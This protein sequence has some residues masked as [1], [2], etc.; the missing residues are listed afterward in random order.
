MEIVATV[1]VMLMAAGVAAFIFGM[2]TADRYARER[3][4]AVKDALTRQYLRLQAGLD[5]DDAPQPYTL[6]E[7][8]RQ[9]LETNGR[10]VAKISRRA[11]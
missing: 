4:N 11:N 10:A 2:R 6:P 3:E 8:F 1:C 9:K 5:A 7:E